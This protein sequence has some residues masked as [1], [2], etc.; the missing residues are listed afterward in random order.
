[1]PALAVPSLL[2]HDEAG[3]LRVD[4]MLGVSICV[5]KENVC[6]PDM[7]RVVAPGRRRDLRAG[8]SRAQV[9]AAGPAMATSI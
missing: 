1:M 9:A 8:K 2:K 6:V 3:V 4:A 7:K 5:R